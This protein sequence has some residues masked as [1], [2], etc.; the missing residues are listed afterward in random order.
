MFAIPWARRELP[1][2]CRCVPRVGREG[3]GRGAPPPVAL[4]KLVAGKRN[5]LILKECTCPRCLC[6][7]LSR[8]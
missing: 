6:Q 7:Y 8:L 3:E 1:P 4:Q 5:L 2:P